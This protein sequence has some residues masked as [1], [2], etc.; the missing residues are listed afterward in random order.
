MN[1]EL[2]V[3]PHAYYTVTDKSEN[4]TLGDVPAG[5][6]EL[7]AWHERLDAFAVGVCGRQVPGFESGTAKF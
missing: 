4:F 5:E 3:A 2:L 1:A 6:Y 7:V